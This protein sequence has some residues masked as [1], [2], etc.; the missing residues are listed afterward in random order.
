MKKIISILLA[1]VI[2]TSVGSAAVTRTL[3]KNVISS[4]GSNITVTL[5]SDDIT[6]DFQFGLF[7]ETISN[8]Y[9][10]EIVPNPNIVRE[11]TTDGFNSTHTFIGL[12]INNTQ[13]KI[14]PIFG[15]EFTQ[16]IV[17]I[18]GEY[19]DSNNNSGVIPMSLFYS[20]IGGINIPDCILFHTYDKDFNGKIDRPEVIDATV[21]YFANKL[22]LTQVIKIIKWYFG[23]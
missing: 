14:T 20:C 12:G 5:T 15:V 16:G 7:N 3:D 2:L 13:Y 8:K 22:T 10:V 11:S 17:N 19:K 9:T 23:V 21:D 6:N 18:T 4:G 1:L